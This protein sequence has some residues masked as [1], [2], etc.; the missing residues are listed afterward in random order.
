[1]RRLLAMCALLLVGCATSP[2]HRYSQLEVGMTK[3]QVFALLG[4]PRS[5][6]SNG[7]LITMEYDLAQQ[8]PAAFHPGQPPVSRYYIIIGRDDL[9]RSFGPN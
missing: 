7:A 8:R 4:P 1:M 3:Q 5:S 6:T 9:I 2:Q